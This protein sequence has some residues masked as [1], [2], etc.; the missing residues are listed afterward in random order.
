M[1]CRI[2]H[3]QNLRISIPNMGCVSFLDS[4]HIVCFTGVF[5]CL[6]KTKIA[7][8]CFQIGLRQCI[9]CVFLLVVYG[10]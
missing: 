8:F 10:F 1:I 4:K 7:F 6:K 5:G 3:M 2:L 9:K